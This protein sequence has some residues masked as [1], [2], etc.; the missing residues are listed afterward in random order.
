MVMVHTKAFWYSVYNTGISNT[1]GRYVMQKY[2]NAKPPEHTYIMG[3]SSLN[4]TEAE[5]SGLRSLN[6]FII[7]E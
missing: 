7:V 4:G 6:A 3:Q 1:S 5:M 2:L